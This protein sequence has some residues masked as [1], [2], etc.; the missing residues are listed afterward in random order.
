MLESFQLI[1]TVSLGSNSSS[2]SPWKDD[3]RLRGSDTFSQTSLVS[4]YLQ[5]TIRTCS[6]PFPSFFISS[7]SIFEERPYDLDPYFSYLLFSFIVLLGPWPKNRLINWS[8]NHQKAPSTLA[9]RTTGIF[10]QFS[11]MQKSVQAHWLCS[12]SRSTFHI[13]LGR[14][15]LIGWWAGSPGSP[16][17][18]WL[19]GVMVLPRRMLCIMS[20]QH[21]Q[22]YHTFAA[23]LN[24]RV[25]CRVILWNNSW[26]Y[27]HETTPKGRL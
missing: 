22:N 25:Q 12:D 24:L 19:Q 16:V 3:L 1:A 23:C 13:Y 27:H 5:Q 26:N 14:Q 9:S 11:S 15:E 21:T 20:T 7:W 8:S 18:W 6:L 2:S 4:S 17:S 10:H